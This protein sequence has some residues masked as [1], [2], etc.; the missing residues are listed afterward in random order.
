MDSQNVLEMQMYNVHSG[1]KMIA[2]DDER[3]R[4]V[5]SDIA[6]MVKGRTKDKDIHGRELS[7]AWMN[8]HEDY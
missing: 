8:E 4:Y 2:Q 6:M 1:V 3:V 5:S 7:D